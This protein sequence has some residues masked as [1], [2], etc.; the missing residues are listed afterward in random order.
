ME[1]LLDRK[2]MESVAKIRDTESGWMDRRSFVRKAG[3]LAVG[4]AFGCALSGCGGDDGIFIPCLGPA[5]APVP[6]AGMTYIWASKIG[7]ALDCDLHSGRNKYTGGEA[8]D[9]APRINAAMA[10][11]SASNPITLIIDGSAL[12]SGLFLPAGGFWSIA[13]LGCGTGFFVKSGTNNDGIHNGGPNAAVPTDPGPPAPARGMNV[14]LSNF[15]LNGNQG[16]GHNGDSTTGMRQGSTAANLWYFGINLMN[17]DNI[18][19]ENVVVV[20]TPA[21]HI[22]LSNVGNVAASGCVMRSVGINTD[23]LHFDGPA[24]D[25][26]ISNCNFTVGDDAIALN[27]P[28]GHTGNISRV[29]V[30]N[31]TFNSL[32]LVRLDTI[33][34]SGSPYKFNIDTVTVS[35]CSGTLAQAGFLFG[36]G[37]GSNPNSVTALTVSDCSLTAP[38]ILDISANFGTVVL[39]NVTLIPS[40]SNQAPGLAFV[41]TV[42][43]FGIV[44]Y[45]GSSLSINNCVVLNNE[46]FPVAALILEYGSTIYNLEFNG[47]TVQAGPGTSFFTAPELLNIVSGSIGQL[48]INTLNN[49]SIEAPVSPGGFGSI[50]SVSGSGVLATGWAFPD[51]VMANGVPYISANTGLPSIKIA[52]VVEPYPQG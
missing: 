42:P 39:R 13:G 40:K 31:C 28:E 20:N 43:Y 45:V 23:G 26:T 41:R 33:G 18:T 36:D 16:N 30:A 29:S 10:G 1:A 9:D 6:V 44:T 17:L 50:G 22:R 32:S 11:A 5:A 12:I 14:S 35:N 4:S 48:V 24:N 15:T 3:L 51:S 49:Q 46:D 19:I 2:R 27:C 7:C 47:F 21:Y 37:T 38:A 52:G 8:T 25:I 34:W